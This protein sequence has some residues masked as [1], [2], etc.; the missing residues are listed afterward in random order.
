MSNHP[1]KH[2]SS[3]YHTHSCLLVHKVVA[4]LSCSACARATSRLPATAAACRSQIRAGRRSRTR[5]TAPTSRSSCCRHL[6]QREERKRSRSSCTSSARIHSEIAAT[7]CTT[8]RGSSDCVAQAA[9]SWPVLEPT[10]LSSTHYPLRH[11]RQARV[12]ARSK[13]N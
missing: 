13:R 12:I 8:H 7:A 4:Q 6:R 2:I 10:R 9:G 5:R 11:T 1:N 3:F